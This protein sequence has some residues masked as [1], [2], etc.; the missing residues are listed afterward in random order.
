MAKSAGNINLGVK[1][2]TSSVKQQLNAL[3]KKGFEVGKLNDKDFTQPLGRIKGSLGEFDKSLAASNA[4]V[5]AFGASAGAIYG[6]GRALKETLVAAVKVESALAEI[7]VILGTSGKNL[8][9]FGDTVFNIGTSGK[10]G[11]E[12]IFKTLG[13]KK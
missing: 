1:L 4:R 9:Q 6:V 5:L 10:I 12:I 13:L 8:A 3:K 11:A 2:D 7:N